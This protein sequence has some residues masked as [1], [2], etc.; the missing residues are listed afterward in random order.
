MF[1]ASDGV[2]DCYTD[3]ELAKLV[4]SN[5]T[6]NE[7]LAAFVRKSRELYGKQADDISFVRKFF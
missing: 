4:L 3:D 2:H 1:V 5:K 6:D 7:L